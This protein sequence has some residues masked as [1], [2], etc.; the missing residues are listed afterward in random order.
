MIRDEHVEIPQAR[1]A[2]PGG[3][4]ITDRHWEQLRAHLLSD[5]NEHAALLMCGVSRRPDRVDFLVRSVV[6]LTAE[7]YLDSGELHLSISPRSLA[8]HVKRA[9]ADGATLVLCHSH[10][11]PGQVLASPIDLATELE[12]CGRVF[13]GRLAGLPTA[14]LIVGPD[15]LDGRVWDRAASP[16]THVTVIGSRIECLPSNSCGISDSTDTEDGLQDTDTSDATTVRQALLWG[17]AG[18]RLLRRAHVAVIG[19]G[20]TGSHAV[21]QLAHLRIGAMTLVD[22]DVVE[23]SNLSRL[24]GAVPTDVGCRKVDVLADHARGINPS[25]QVVAHG[26][27]V[28]D[29]DPHALL[30]ADVI[31]CATDGHG[32]RALL[33]E[34]AQQYLIPIVDLGVEVD[35]SSDAFRAGGG[36]RVLRPGRGCLHCSR[37]LSPALVREEYLDDEQ[38]HV[39][40]QRG[41][42]RGE[43][44]PAPSVV[45]LNG[46]VASLAV[47]EVCQLLVGML[48]DGRDR[49]LYRAESRALS[50][51]SMPSDSDCYVC[52]ADGLLGMGDARPLPTRWHPA[53][54]AV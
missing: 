48:G 25:V 54:E 30:E 18:Q 4:R 26:V 34:I 50:T 35:P 52:G 37:T 44:A 42:I 13:P 2:V 51:A 39:E 46:V 47:L 53:A 33:T 19:C 49:L 1:R 9:R 14:A 29:V 27:S 8:R 31:V 16:L 32:S 28:L 12:L 23:I 38:R 3:L 17:D 43:A 40:V 15:G 6:E 21:T 20:G 41:Y 11:F 22:H 10:P 36:V 45:A 7:D 24:V 5:R